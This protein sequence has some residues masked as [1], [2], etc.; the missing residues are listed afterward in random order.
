MLFHYGVT[1][2]EQLTLLNVEILQNMELEDPEL[3][4]AIIEAAREA[5]TGNIRML[6]SSNEEAKGGVEPT[7]DMFV[8]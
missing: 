4:N 1:K 8:E 3:Q 7:G 5:A 2:L 6:Q